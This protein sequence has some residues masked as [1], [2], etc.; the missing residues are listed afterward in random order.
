MNKV[1]VIQTFSFYSLGWAKRHRR[2]LVRCAT[3]ACLG[4]FFLRPNKTEPATQATL[5]T[6]Q[7]YREFLRG[8]L[9][10]SLLFRKL[11]IGHTRVLG[12]TRVSWLLRNPIFRRYYF[13]FSMNVKELLPSVVR[14][15]WMIDSNIRYV[16]QG[17]RP[18]T[19]K[20][21]APIVTSAF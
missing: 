13:F 12:S 8:R 10:T 18:S 2:S 21:F 16:T 1:L 14:D 3:F 7:L 9:G 5:E 4:D 15:G 19:D 20:G 6:A 17:G 11:R